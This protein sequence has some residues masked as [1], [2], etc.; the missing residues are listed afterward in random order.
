MSSLSSP[1]AAPEVSGL[2][3]NALAALAMLL[4]QYCLGMS[5]NLY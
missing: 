1:N 4:V 2:R 3:A 5:V